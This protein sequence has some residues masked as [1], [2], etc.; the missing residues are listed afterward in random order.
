MKEFL[1]NLIKPPEGPPDRLGPYWKRGLNGMWYLDSLQMINDGLYADQIK[2][3]RQ[4]AEQR[5][6]HPTS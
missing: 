5:E 3:A 6:L 4:L 1:R 2:A